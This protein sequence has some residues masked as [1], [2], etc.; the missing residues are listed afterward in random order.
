LKQS[1]EVGKM[2]FFQHEEA[3]SDMSKI[4]P[5]LQEGRFDWLWFHDIEVDVNKALTRMNEQGIQ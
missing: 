4:L 3:G 2:I 1:A 5:R